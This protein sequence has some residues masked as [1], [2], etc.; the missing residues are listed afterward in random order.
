MQAACKPYFGNLQVDV[1]SYLAKTA[2]RIA[3][4]PSPVRIREGPLLISPRKTRGNH[5]ILWV[6]VFLRADGF[7]L[8]LSQIVSRNSRVRAKATPLETVDRLAPNGTA[9]HH[10]RYRAV[11]APEPIRSQ[12]SEDCGD[13]RVEM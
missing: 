1:N 4:P 6:F 12:E 2:L 3:N 7:R 11:T 8:R 10:E 9:G 5:D 13:G